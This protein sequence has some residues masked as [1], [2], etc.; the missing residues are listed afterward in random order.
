MEQTNHRL[1]PSCVLCLQNIPWL[2][3]IILYVGEQ[4]AWSSSKYKSIVS[5]LIHTARKALAKTH[6]TWPLHLLPQWLATIQG[7]TSWHA[8]SC[9]NLPQ[10]SRALNLGS[11][12][13]LEEP[14]TSFYLGEC[15]CSCQRRSKAATP[16]S[17]STTT[18][19]L[20]GADRQKSDSVTLRQH[21]CS[22]NGGKGDFI[23]VLS[24]GDA[25]RKQQGAHKG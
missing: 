4:Q 13:G 19:C 18:A 17:S 10:L 24:V 9:R 20:P 11:M 8:Q 14:H 7:N 15:T 3:P 21:K 1:L 12:L 16:C 23:L 5:S 6:L 2:L 25:E 22:Q